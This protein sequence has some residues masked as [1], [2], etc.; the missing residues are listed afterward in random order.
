[1]QGRC[2]N[3]CSVRWPKR[4]SGGWRGA[5][6]SWQGQLLDAL[7]GDASGR[8]L[9]GVRHQDNRDVLTSLI[10]GHIRKAVH[11][12]AGLLSLRLRQS[13]S[14]I[15]VRRFAFTGEC[16]VDGTFLDGVVERRRDDELIDCACL[17]DPM[18]IGPIGSEV[19]LVVDLAFRSLK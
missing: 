8:V 14:S 5:P 10:Q 12:G 7:R 15:I 2:R 17:A 18:D 16:A 3:G 13:L 9:V 11:G 19:A 6:L 1:M 4:T